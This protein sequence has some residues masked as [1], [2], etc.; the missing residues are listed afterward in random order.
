MKEWLHHKLASLGSD[1]NNVLD[2]N[3][4]AQ[5]IE[6]DVNLHRMFKDSRI[7]PAAPTNSSRK[8]SRQPRTNSSTAAPT[9]SAPRSN[10]G[11]QGG[12]RQ[13]KGRDTFLNKYNRTSSEWEKI[14]A[15]GV[16]VRCLK[17]SHRPND[18]NAPCKDKPP[19][20]SAQVQFLRVAQLAAYDS[21]S[22]NGSNDDTDYEDY[23]YSE[24]PGNVG[25]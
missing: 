4:R 12:Q 14:K 19:T 24:Q 17:D 22:N 16:C 25:L 11:A 13:S 18:D 7:G 23:E 10:N 15:K 6:A 3:R 5:D 21:E 20:A 8:F 1:Y 2:F 9:G